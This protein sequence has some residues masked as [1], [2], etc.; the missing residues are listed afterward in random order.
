MMTDGACSELDEELRRESRLTTKLA[1][2]DGLSYDRHKIPR[3]TCSD[4][5]ACKSDTG[6]RKRLRREY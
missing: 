5:P 6:Y 2:E 3:I 1:C 4:N